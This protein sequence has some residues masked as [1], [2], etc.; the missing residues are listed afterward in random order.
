MGILPFPWQ[1]FYTV[2][3]RPE[4]AIRRGRLKGHPGNPEPQMEDEPLA[5]KGGS[6][7]K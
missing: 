1:A 4:L 6:Q 7:K 3:V 5:Q 2:P